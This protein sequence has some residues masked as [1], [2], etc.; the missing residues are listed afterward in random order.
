MHARKPHANRRTRA[1]ARARGHTH[2]HTHTATCLAFTSS[3]LESVRDVTKEGKQYQLNYASPFT[4]VTLHE[5]HPS[6]REDRDLRTWSRGVAEEGHSRQEL[7]WRSPAPLVGAWS[8][9][10]GVCNEVGMVRD[11][12]QP[13]IVLNIDPVCSCPC[14]RCPVSPSQRASPLP[15]I[16][17][18]TLRLVWRGWSPEVYVF[19]RP[20]NPK[21]IA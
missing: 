12:S 18:S 19:S 5:V 14:F 17:I 2:T 20:K 15:R 10:H 8:I 9:G 7:D 21:M 3:L 16:R 1:R 6:L 4:H 11:P 13:R